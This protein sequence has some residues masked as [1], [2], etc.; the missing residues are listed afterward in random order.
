VRVAGRGGGRLRDGWAV[1]YKRFVMIELFIQCPVNNSFNITLALL[2]DIATT[3]P[4]RP[5]LLPL[6]PFSYPCLLLSIEPS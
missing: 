3:L 2:T 5:S 4:A 6:S 1:Y